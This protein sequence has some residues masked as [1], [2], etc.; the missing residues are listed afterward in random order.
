[1]SRVLLTNQ[2]SRVGASCGSE[3]GGNHAGADLPA[4][5]KFKVL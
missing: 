2:F 1:M 5:D 4:L 3:H